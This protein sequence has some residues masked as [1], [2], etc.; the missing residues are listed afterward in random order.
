MPDDY[1][2]HG[3]ESSGINFIEE[4][5]SNINGAL[6]FYENNKLVRLEV[7]DEGVIT[8]TECEDSCDDQYPG[9][10]QC[11]YEGVGQCVRHT[12]FTMGTVSKIGCSFGF[13]ACIAYATAD[14]IE[15]NCIN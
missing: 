13:P 8:A 10:D 12:M 7:I 15:A 5:I 1:L 4:N 9:R 2:N 14:C 6:K 11:S 3:M